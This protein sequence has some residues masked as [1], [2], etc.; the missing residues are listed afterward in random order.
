MCVRHT[1][2]QAGRAKAGR[3]GRQHTGM[4]GVKGL[5]HCAITHCATVFSNTLYCPERL[6]VLGRRSCRSG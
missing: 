3:Q 4:D 6:S 2:M 1:G 5:T